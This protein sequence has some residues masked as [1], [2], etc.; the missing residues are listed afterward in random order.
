MAEKFEV[1]QWVPFRLEV[2]FAFFA[3][4]GELPLLMPPRM[5][6]R[7]EELDLTAPKKAR[8]PLP[9]LVGKLPDVAA[10]VGSEILI[11]FCPFAWPR[12]RMKARVRITEFEWNYHF[13]DRQIQGPFRQF[14]HSHTTKATVR[15]GVQG[16]MV[17]DTIKYSLPYGAIGRMGNGMIHRNL[18]EM[19]EHRQR[20]L[21]EVLTAAARLAAN[22]G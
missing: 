3:N 21:T 12:V 1:S 9:P 13:R 15:K 17:T 20:R 11:S 8:P 6:T 2:V 4:P 5:E 10:G 7:I 22:C 19:F 14:D 18:E 16:T